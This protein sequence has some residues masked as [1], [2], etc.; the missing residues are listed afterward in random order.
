MIPLQKKINELKEPQPVRIITSPVS[1]GGGSD[2][3]RHHRDNA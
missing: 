2:Q 1:R 3:A